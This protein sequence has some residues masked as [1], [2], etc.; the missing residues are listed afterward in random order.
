MTAAIE[1]EKFV[2]VLERKEDKLFIHSPREAHKSHSVC[3][4]AV[5]LDTGSDN[6]VFAC[7]EMDYGEREDKE[8]TINT[9]KMRKV[10][11]YYE[12]DFGMNTVIRKKELTVD[13]TA[14][15]L[16]P[17]PAGA[18]GPGGLLVV[19]EDYL[20]YRHNQE[21][22]LL[23]FPLRRARPPSRKTQFTCH[24]IYR[25]KGFFF[26]ISSEL[27]DLYK[28]ELSFKEHKNKK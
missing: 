12:M 24:T 4:D 14:H 16:V 17:V 2:Y 15:M 3:M 18:E 20:M 13:P 21:E 25:F 5:G 7:L 10:V 22:H 19:L 27:G 28:V 9:G 1:K 6:A 23:R 8:A 26:L 11:A